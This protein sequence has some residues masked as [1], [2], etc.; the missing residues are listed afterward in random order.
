MEKWI[1]VEACLDLGICQTFPTPTQNIFKNMVAAYTFFERAAVSRHTV[2]VRVVV[3]LHL[4]ETCKAQVSES[5]TCKKNTL[6]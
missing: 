3:R 4:C 5:E 2:C 6:V 1:C